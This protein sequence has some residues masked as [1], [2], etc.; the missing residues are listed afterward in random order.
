MSVE[1]IG[2]AMSWSLVGRIAAFAAGFGANVL[3]VRAISAVE[4]GILSEI[5]TIL[6]FVLVVVMIIAL[7]NR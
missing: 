5:K 2:R 1:K 3:I 4:W 7:A 6:Q